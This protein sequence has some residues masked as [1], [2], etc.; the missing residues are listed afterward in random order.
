MTLLKE[1]STALKNIAGDSPPSTLIQEKV[2]LDQI[3]QLDPDEAA[4]DRNEQLIDESDP[5]VQEQMRILNGGGAGQRIVSDELIAE[6]EDCGTEMLATYL[7]ES[8]RCSDCGDS[9]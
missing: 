5:E 8:G 9:E 4:L 3:I 7:D 1:Y 2:L 6:C